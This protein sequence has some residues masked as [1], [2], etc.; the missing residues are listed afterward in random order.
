MSIEGLSVWWPGRVSEGL[1]VASA[2]DTEVVVSAETEVVLTTIRL[3]SSVM[4][5]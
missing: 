1:T 5:R 4:I 3:K 2:I